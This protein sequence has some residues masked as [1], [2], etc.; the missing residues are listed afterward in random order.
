MERQAR[1]K[2]TICPRNRTETNRKQLKD[3]QCEIHWEMNAC[4]HESEDN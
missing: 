1:D 2:A 3:E 4:A